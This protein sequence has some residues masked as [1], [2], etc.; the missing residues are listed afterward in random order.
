MIVPV[1][2]GFFG[3]HVEG[4][5][6]GVGTFVRDDGSRFAWHGYS[7]FFTWFDGSTWPAYCNRTR[8]PGA[9][10]NVPGARQEVWAYGPND[11]LY[12]GKYPVNIFTGSALVAW[13]YPIAPGEVL[14]L[15]APRAAGMADMG[16]QSVRPAFTVAVSGDVPLSPKWVCSSWD[17]SCAVIYDGKF[18]YDVAASV[19]KKTGVT[20]SATTSK[21]RY[22]VTLAYTRYIDSVGRVVDIEKNALY[23]IDVINL[24]EGISLGTVTITAASGLSETVQLSQQ[25]FHLRYAFNGKPLAEFKTILHDVG[26]HTNIKQID[27]DAY[28]QQ[29]GIYDQ[30]MSAWLLGE[31]V[32]SEVTFPRTSMLGH[33]FALNAGNVFSL[34][35]WD[36]PD[37]GS[38]HVDFAGFGD[39]LAGSPYTGSAVIK[40]SPDAVYLRAI[41]PGKIY[42]S[43]NEKDQSF[44]FV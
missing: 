21:V 18:F 7:P 20:N 1:S 40:S 6:N 42:L 29:H 35:C 28:L 25:V 43:D 5:A 30:K 26:E 32:L 34:Q 2:M 10:H 39:A 15:G 27:V 14:W 31:E 13:L 19:V 37:G 38:K 44:F 17:G 3:G 8:V 9:P 11:C 36:I 16:D 23:G 33:T 12:G 22:E 41:A 24:S 4:A